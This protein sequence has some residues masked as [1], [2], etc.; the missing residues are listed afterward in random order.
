MIHAT[1]WMALKNIS[2]SEI[3]QTLIYINF[4]GNAKL[5]PDQCFSQRAREVGGWHIGTKQF[6]DFRDG[7]ITINLQKAIELYTK[8]KIFMVYKLY[9]NI[10]L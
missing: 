9:F 2:Q 3:N 7:Y 8:W 4:L 6:G 10:I 1:A 5:R